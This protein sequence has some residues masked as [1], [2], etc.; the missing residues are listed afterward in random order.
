MPDET[1]TNPAPD[2]I[3]AAPPT[4]DVAWTSGSGEWDTSPDWC[5]DGVTE[6]RRADLCEVLR[7]ERDALVLV[8]AGLDARL[9]EAKALADKALSQG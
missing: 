3:Y 1:K 9:D 7:A 4:F 6:Y 5:A 2:V 8:V